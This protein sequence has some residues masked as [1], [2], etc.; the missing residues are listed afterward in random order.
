MI[1]KTPNLNNQSPSPSTL[2][3][4]NSTPEES[5]P[6]VELLW[7][8]ESYWPDIPPIIGSSKTLGVDLGEN[9]DSSD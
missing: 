6:T 1:S 9:K 2:R 5:S 8:M 3:P 7:T 4:G